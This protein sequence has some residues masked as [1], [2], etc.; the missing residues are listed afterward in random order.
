MSEQ[1]VL[2]DSLGDFPDSKERGDLL[3]K[4]V[5]NVGSQ[6][7]EA[8]G[9]IENDNIYSLNKRMYNIKHNGMV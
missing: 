1:S 9:H 8:I 3:M 7:N 5:N 4:I 2:W 6:V